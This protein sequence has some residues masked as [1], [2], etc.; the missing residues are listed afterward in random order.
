[1]ARHGIGFIAIA[2]VIISLALNSAA[3]A[4]CSKDKVLEMANAGTT[5]KSISGTCSMTVAQ[6]KKILDGDNANANANG[7]G[8]G[9]GNPL[10]PQLMPQGMPLQACGCYG[11]VPFG[12]TTVAPQ[13]KSGAAIAAPCPGMCQMGGSPWRLVCG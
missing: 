8:S 13:C 10:P 5:I 4:A 7:N 9:N 12:Y 6:V 1:M 3:T 2:V 11:F